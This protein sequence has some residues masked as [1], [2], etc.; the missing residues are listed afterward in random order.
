MSQQPLNLPTVVRIKRSQGRVVQDFDVYIGRECKIGGWDLPNSKWANPYTIKRYGSAE[1]VVKKY[2]ELVLKSETLLSSLPELEGK[3]LGCWCK[4]D[5]CHG[6]VLVDLF[7]R[8]VNKGETAESL[9]MPSPRKS[10]VVTSY[11]SGAV[12]HNEGV[13]YVNGK[14]VEDKRPS[15]SSSP[16]SSSTSGTAVYNNFGGNNCIMKN[17]GNIT[18]ISTN[19]KKK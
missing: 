19:K 8:I 15:S 1:I 4:P 17:T 11:E 3:I 14:L 9:L 2:R 18:L 7:D 5:P 13:I 16:S 12:L 10:R 6:D